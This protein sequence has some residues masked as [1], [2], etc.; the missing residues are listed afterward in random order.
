[1]E[2]SEVGG[3]DDSVYHPKHYNSDPSGVECIQ[4]VRH[5]NFNV[6][7]AIKYL[8]RCGLKI[9]SGKTSLGSEI[10]DLKKARWYIDDEIK[11]LE[12]LTVTYAATGELRADKMTAEEAIE[13]VLKRPGMYG[14]V[15]KEGSKS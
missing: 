12:G 3:T 6:G 4:V 15:A 5:R 7:N 2:R 8:W 9:V 1:M 11:R 13:S 10:Q 14:L